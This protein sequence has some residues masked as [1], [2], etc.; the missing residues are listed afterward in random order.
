M[1]H[2][3]DGVNLAELYFEPSPVGPENPPNFTPMNQIVRSE[4][5]KLAGFDP[6]YLFVEKSSHYW[7][8]DTIGWR[9]FADYRKA[10]CMI[11]KI[12]MLDYLTKIKEKKKDFELML[13]VIDVSLTPEL[14][15]NI[16]EDTQNALKLYSEYPITLQVEDPSNCWGSTP[17]RYDKMGR[18]YR[19]YV[20]V[21]NEL[22]FDCNVVASHEKG[23]GG[24]P[25]EKPTG[26]EI[27]QITYNMNLSHSRPTFYSEDAI[28][29]NDFRNI[30]S[31]LAHETKIK[32]ISNH[33][34]NVTSPNSVLICTGLNGVEVRMD[35]KPWRAQDGD[36]IIVPSGVHQLEFSKMQSNKNLGHILLISGELISSTFLSRGFELT[37]FED[38]APCY[39]TVDKKVTDVQV[40]HKPY[41]PE[42]VTNTS[43][44]YTLKL[45]RGKHH[46]KVYF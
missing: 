31:V 28:F 1:K 38:T 10:L 39:I 21:K 4:F 35:G 20:K 2:D 3:W 16:A 34:W 42:I 24:F 45:P 40:D 41:I 5:Q 37:Y 23:Y 11:L 9:K 14:S 18:F 43:D 25:S 33:S 32:E 44:R 36:E 13:T 17:N 15:D 12:K 46:V 19:N 7:K 22:V 6:Y 26:E 8:T 29:I 27:R 30:S